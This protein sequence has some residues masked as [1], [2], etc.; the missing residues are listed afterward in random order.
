[1]EDFA[2]V[3]GG[4]RNIGAAIARRLSD[5]GFKIIVI[6]QIEPDHTHVDAF[7]EADLSDV[8]SLAR[9]LAPVFDERRITR[10]VNNDNY[11]GLRWTDFIQFSPEEAEQ[12]LAGGYQQLNAA[13]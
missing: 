12:I 1:M 3:T 9:V 11:P 7:V 6:D 2:V 5:D 10:L 13:R 8:R 4:A